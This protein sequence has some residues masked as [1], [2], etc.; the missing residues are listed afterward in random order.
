MIPYSTGQTYH[1]YRIALWLR[2]ITVGSVQ[3]ANGAMLPFYRMV[4]LGWLHWANLINA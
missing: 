1:V 4:T 3:W 2:L